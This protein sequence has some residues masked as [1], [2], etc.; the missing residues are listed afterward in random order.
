MEMICTLHIGPWCAVLMKLVFSQAV[1]VRRSSHCATYIYGSTL[2]ELW[3]TYWSSHKFRPVCEYFK[4]CGLFLPG[5]L[6]GMEVVLLLIS[7][8]LIC[9]V[10]SEFTN[11]YSSLLE[12][13]LQTLCLIWLHKSVQV[14]AASA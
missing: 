6:L 9:C 8:Y 4:S 5:P 11:L 14:P 3:L 13:Y 12:W 2:R 1:T 7:V 10:I